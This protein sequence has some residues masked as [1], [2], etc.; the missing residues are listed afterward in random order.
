VVA[1]R[2]FDQRDVRPEEQGSVTAPTNAQRAPFRSAIVNESFVRRYLGGRDPIGARLG[3]G[4]GPQVQPSIEIVGVVTDFSYRGLREGDDQAFYPFFED[5]ISAAT[6][7]ARTRTRSDAAFGVVRAALRQHDPQLPLID[8]RTIED[9]LDRSLVNERLM[10]TLAGAFAVLAV[11]L[12]VAGLYGVTAFVVS[13][14]TREIGIRLAL[15]S[16]RRRALWVV[17]RDTA[18]MLAAGLAVALPAVWALGRLV[19]SQLFG[20]RALD[21]GTIAAAIGVIALTALAASA[22]P[23]RRAASVSPTEALRYE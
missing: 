3:F 12:A 22:V 15:G 7:Y 2:G 18:V 14:R 6:F 4:T 21:P 11:A 10:A 5:T 8:L 19:E 1:G 20:L 9:Q 23:A 17:L 13:R 16:S